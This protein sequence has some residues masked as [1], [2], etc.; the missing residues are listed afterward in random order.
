MLERGA[1]ASL[2][3]KSYLMQHTCPCMHKHSA[4]LVSFKQ[5]CF[6]QWLLEVMILLLWDNLRWERALL[7]ERRFHFAKKKKDKSMVSAC[8]VSGISPPWYVTLI[9]APPLSQ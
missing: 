2:I 3:V 9:T 8:L 6:L 7:V 1:G 5:A 4:V